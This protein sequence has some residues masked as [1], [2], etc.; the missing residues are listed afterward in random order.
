MRRDMVSVLWEF[1]PQMI[2]LNFLF[3]YLSILIIAKWFMGTTPDLYHVMINMFLKPGFIDEQGYVFAGQGG[4]Q[5]CDAVCC[6]CLLAR[7]EQLFMPCVG[8]KASCQ[9]PPAIAPHTLH[10]TC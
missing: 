6:V 1:I 4:L 5:V 3:G 7:N 2:F 8:L 9:L 10:P